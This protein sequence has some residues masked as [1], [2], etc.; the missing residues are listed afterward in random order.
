M[1]KFRELADSYVSD[2]GYAQMDYLL[3]LVSYA[4]KTIIE[5]EMHLNRSKKKDQSAN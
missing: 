3:A 5:R 4:N 2:K 1:S